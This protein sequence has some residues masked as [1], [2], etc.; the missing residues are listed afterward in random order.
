MIIQYDNE[1]INTNKC[2]NIKLYY[3]EN[4]LCP[5]GI[6][7]YKFIYLLSLEDDSRV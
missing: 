5:F 3:E 7:I 1:L 4:Y 6:A 2:I